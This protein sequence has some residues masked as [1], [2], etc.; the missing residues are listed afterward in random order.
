MDVVLFSFVLLA[1][2][3]FVARPLYERRRA[4]TTPSD[5]GEA[6]ATHAEDSHL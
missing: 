6:Q 2:T 5:A 3:A 4:E 1:L